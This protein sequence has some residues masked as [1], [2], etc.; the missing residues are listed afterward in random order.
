MKNF[1]RRLLSLAL[2]LVLILSISVLFSGCYI[3]RSAKMK[4]VEGTYELTTY[5]GDGDWLTERGIK[6][7]MVIRS[8]GTGYYGYTD[9]N[10][11]PHISELRCRF[12]RDTEDN[13]KYQYVEIDFEGNGE[14]CQLGI[15]ADRKT[16]KLNYS[17]I[18]WKGNVIQNGL[19]VD[20]HINVTFTRIDKAT[21][22]SVL[23]KHFAG[24][25]VIPFG[26]SKYNGTYM[27][28]RLD[29]GNYPDVEGYTPPSPFVYYYLDIDVYAGKARAY[30]MSTSNE[31]ADEQEY[32]IVITKNNDGSFSIK[33]GGK[34]AEIV[35]E[36]FSVYIHAP[37]LIT[38][39]EY[40]K[41]RYV[42][43]M[44]HESIIMHCENA[45]ASYLA[46]LQPQ[47]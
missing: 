11:A 3:T 47:E 46:G 34:V 14:Y 41:F 38:S 4:F 30:S 9:N 32:P 2:V 45:Y 31:K 15:N 7:I 37:Y 33:I 10:K 19:Q 26:A 18:K 13:D 24:A 5:S 12:T 6:L 42:G 35:N 22:R 8:D 23:D 20:Y 27:F 36:N 25:P 29:G 21:D 16:Q 39:G 17:T 44:S 40:M 1:K 28:E 43:D